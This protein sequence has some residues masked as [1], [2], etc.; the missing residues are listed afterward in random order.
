MSTYGGFMIIVV[1]VVEAPL[2]LIRA[3]GELTW[4]S[5]GSLTFI[6]FTIFFVA[7]AGQ[8]EANHFHWP[9]MWPDNSIDVLR[10]LGTFAYAYS[11]Q[12]VLFEAYVAMTPEAKKNFDWSVFGSVCWGG[13]LLTL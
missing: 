13:T 8:N 11:C 9:R 10:Q 7:I 12:Y 1:G 4:I 5:F 2:I 3:Y 6:C